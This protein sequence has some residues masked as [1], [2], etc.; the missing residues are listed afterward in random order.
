MMQPLSEAGVDSLGAV[1][2]RNKLE[3]S[4]GTKLPATVTFDYP[5]TAA[6]ASF[7]ATRMSPPHQDRAANA[8]IGEQARSQESVEQ[9]IQDILRAMLGN[10]V[11]VDQVSTNWTWVEVLCLLFCAPSACLPDFGASANNV[12]GWCSIIRVCITT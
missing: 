12:G 10:E 5:T 7:L 4:L 9:D 8:P 11:Q 2:L 1:E 6:L 3:A